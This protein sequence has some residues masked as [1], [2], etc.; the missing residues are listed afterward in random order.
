MF[1][2]SW[3][4]IR[5]SGRIQL[6]RHCSRSCCLGV[7][8]NVKMQSYKLEDVRIIIQRS[9]FLIRI[10]LL[11]ST[12]MLRTISQS[13][14]CTLISC[15]RDKDVLSCISG[16]LDVDMDIVIFVQY[17]EYGYIPAALP[18]SNC[19]GAESGAVKTQS[20]ATAA[21]PE[22]TAVSNAAPA[23]PLPAPSQA[24]SELLDKVVIQLFSACD[25]LAGP[26]NKN[27]IP[28]SLHRHRLQ[29]SSVN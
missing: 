2:R 18:D 12:H 20:K 1:C 28:D 7:S 23:I 24:F 21:S 27:F 16:K 29:Y 15:A 17:K 8:G 26:L 11:N 22:Q 3:R 25:P 19:Y 6:C 10:L 13:S 4:L 9:Q 5:G 14:S